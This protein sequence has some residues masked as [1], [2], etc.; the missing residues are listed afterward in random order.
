MISY[1]KGTILHIDVAYAELATK[2]VGYK[3]Q[4][5]GE[6]LSTLTVGSEAELFVYTH[7]KEDA[8]DLYGFDTRTK[9]SLFESLISVSGIGPKSALGVLSVASVDEIE[10]AIVRGDASILEKV[11]GIGKKT[12]ERIV[13]ELKNKYKGKTELGESSGGSDDA[14]VIDA[15]VGLGYSADQARQ[16]F[17]S[18]DSSIEGVDEK[19][20]A[21]LK[22]LGK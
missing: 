7:V 12:A 5:P 15:L 20:K 22:E 9:R 3:V 8:F 4:L 16:A 21:C 6:L 19:V 11:S 17:R 1:L 2:D 14:D 13:L 10:S 18:I